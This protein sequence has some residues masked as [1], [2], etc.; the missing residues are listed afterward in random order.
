MQISNTPDSMT[1]SSQILEK[2]REKH[3]DNEFCWTPDGFTSRNGKTY[4]P[5]DLTI[6]KVFRFEG[7]SNPSDMEIIYIIRANDGFIGYSQ[8]A[9]GVYSSHEE[10][11]G[12]DN[13]IRRI[14][15]T[16]HDQQ[17]SFEL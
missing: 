13:F 3:F 6:L 11:E 4:Q 5:T 12:Y 14:P 9:Y 10:E 8:D 16:G 1:S 15:E 7:E 2:L 17:L